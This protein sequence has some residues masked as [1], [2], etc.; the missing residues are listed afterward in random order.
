[1]SQLPGVRHPHHQLAAAA[2]SAAYLSAA[3]AASLYGQTQGETR[4][5]GAS[6]PGAGPGPPH[7][8][9]TQLAVAEAMNQNVYAVSIVVKPKMNFLF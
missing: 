5:A 4:E 2:S 6:A 3:K 1:M 9:T 8:W 7:L